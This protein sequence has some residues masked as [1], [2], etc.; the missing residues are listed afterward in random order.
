[1]L[2]KQM[3]EL[4]KER[5]EELEPAMTDARREAFL[6]ARE[7]IRHVVDISLSHAENIL[8]DAGFEADYVD[9]VIADME[10]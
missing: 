8:H 9:V 7:D 4:A 10:V 1:M 2:P 5:L 3:G 6:S